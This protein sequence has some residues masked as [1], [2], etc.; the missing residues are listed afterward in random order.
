MPLQ[1]AIQ[2]W[3]QNFAPDARD[4][5]HGEHEVAGH[6]RPL[7]DCAVGSF[8]LFGERDLAPALAVQPFQKLIHMSDVSL[9]NVQMQAPSLAWLYFTPQGQ[10]RQC[11]YG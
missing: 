4:A 9:A 6:A 8:A 1:F 3:P 11:Q 10:V 2:V 5:F 7:R